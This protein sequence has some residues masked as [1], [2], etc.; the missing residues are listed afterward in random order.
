MVE[1]LLV[2]VA[3]GILAVATA[4]LAA[5]R[6][7]LPP[8]IGYLAAGL[9][10]GQLAA[11][12][13]FFD[14]ATRGAVS[15][16]SILILLFFIGLELDLARLRRAIADTSWAVPFHTLVPLVAVASVGRLAGWSYAESL[17]LGTAIAVSSTLLGERLAIMPGLGAATRHRILGMLVVEDLLSGLLLAIVPLLAT[18]AA[19]AGWSLAFDTVLLLLAVILLA[20]AALLIVPRLLDLVARTHAHELLVLW[21]LALV[22]LFGYLGS[23]WATPELGAFVAGV[24]AA[25]AGSRFTTRHALQGV[26]DTAIA[27]FFFTS[28]LGVNLLPTLQAPLLVLAV[29]GAFLAGKY[30]VNVVAAAASGLNLGQSLRCAFAMGTVGEY[31]LI[32]AA[33][34][35]RAG[36]AHPLLLATVVGAMV[37]T[38]PVSAAM[39]RAAPALER[40]FW[41]LPGRVR[42]GPIRVATALRRLGSGPPEEQSERRQAARRLAANGVLLVALVALLPVI[43][44]V[45]QL[46]PGGPGLAQVVT[47]TAGL[48]LGLPLAWSAFRA[49]REIAWS[50]AGRRPGEVQGQRAARA[51][52]RLLDALVAL[53]FVIVLVPVVLRLPFAWPILAAAAALAALVALVAWRRLTAFHRALEEAVGRILGDETKAVAILDR[54]LQDHPWG[55]RF[56][57]VAVPADSPLVDQTLGGSR[58]AELTGAVV[59]VVQ[60]G[61]REI[62]NPGADESIRAGDTLVLFGEANE[63]ERAEA[64][65]LSHGNAL[66]LSAQSRMAHVLE[67]T[68][69]PDG[70]WAG[71]SLG[72]IDVRGSTGALVV[73]LLRPDSDRGPRRYDPAAVLAPGA[74]LILLGTDLQLERARALAAA[75]P[76]STSIA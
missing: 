52:L 21:G 46:L 59:A 7:S 18:G 53:S 31:G 70:A 45:A 40:A 44:A 43:A 74:R 1:A 60:R 35:D 34:A 47:A 68:I 9:L 20:A 13:Q 17:L 69:A 22:I 61:S 57:A 55:V 39:M 15:Q 36:L 67:V 3:V 64:L 29:A 14:A 10:L 8:V 2:S 38:L 19:A 54:A 63:L 16:V 50:L 12:G 5:H 6:L 23:L 76:D 32:V 56:T 27:A 62:V 11:A 58:L 24:A 30:V 73:G 71:R 75:L 49:Y 65:L 48:A 28:G 25:E 51:R 42:R 33:V 66:R 4:G 37:L 41:R 72:E 26:R